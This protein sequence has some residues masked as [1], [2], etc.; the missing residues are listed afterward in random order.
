MRQRALNGRRALWA[1]AGV[2][3]MLTGCQGAG[4][5]LVQPGASREPVA[6]SGAMPTSPAF[7]QVAAGQSLPMGMRSGGN[8]MP[9]A[10]GQPMV[11]MNNV[12][13]YTGQPVVMNQPIMANQPLVGSGGMVYPVGYTPGG[14]APVGQPVMGGQV[15][16]GPMMSQPAMMMPSGTP[17][18]SVIQTPTGPQYVATPT[19]L[20]PTVAAPVQVPASVPAPIPGPAPAPAPAPIPGPA[21]TY[22]APAATPSFVAPPPAAIP[23]PALPAGLPV[24]APAFKAPDPLPPTVGAVPTPSAGG[25][26]LPA[27]ASDGPRLGSFPTPPAPTP[28][29]G[30]KLPPATGAIDDDI[31]PAP[32][33][34]PAGK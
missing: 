14:P 19:E 16:Q 6:M 13:T 10:Q 15:M 11:M 30:V 7:S 25:A 29:G 34:V 4:T 23:A 5:Q 22:A 21:P 28:S 9:V 2:F 33:F 17:G 31:P 3:A 12:P 8:V 26:V 20:T 18:L 27:A 1:G 24:E 32:I